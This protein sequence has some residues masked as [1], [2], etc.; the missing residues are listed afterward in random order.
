MHGVDE[1]G[2]EFFKSVVEPEDISEIVFV[3]TSEVDF[4]VEVMGS[5]DN[6]KKLFW[7]FIVVLKSFYTTVNVVVIVVLDDGIDFVFGFVCLPQAHELR[8]GHKED[9]IIEEYLLH[10][11][12]KFRVRLG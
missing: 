5:L 4:I 12:F 10:L 6:V 8:I 7:E 1:E 11:E 3:N 9:V 2:F